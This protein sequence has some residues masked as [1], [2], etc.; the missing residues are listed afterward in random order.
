[1]IV[2]DTAVLVID[3]FS[4]LE[5]D[6]FHAMDRITRQR[7]VGLHLVESM[8]FS[9]EILLNC[10]PLTGIFTTV[11]SGKMLTYWC[12]KRSKGRKEDRSFA[13]ILNKVRLGI[14]EEEV[15]RLLTSRVV[16]QWSGGWSQS[17]LHH[18]CIIVALRCKGNFGMRIFCKN[19]K[20]KSMS[21]T[22]LTLMEMETHSVL[23]TRRK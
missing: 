17:W 4:M 1:M 6:V 23:Q 18:C 9:L 5:F 2:K 8:S 16:W 11:D 19:L 13:C 22:P 14:V 7:I 20:R 10:Q 3:E 15:K 12:S 21:L